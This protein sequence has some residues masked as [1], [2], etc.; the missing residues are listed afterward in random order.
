MEKIKSITQEYF[1]TAERDWGEYDGWVIVT[2][3]QTI[4]IGISDG[5]SCCESFGCIVSHDDVSE[6]IGANLRS[7]SVVDTALNARVIEATEYLDEGGAMFV[8]LD[9]SR[10]KLQFAAYNC[11]N[12]YYGHEAV[13]ISKEGTKTESC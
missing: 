12:G 9:T 10:G 4:K 11:H 13:L 3:Q 7:V 2:S 6:F 8:N 1:K 5:Q